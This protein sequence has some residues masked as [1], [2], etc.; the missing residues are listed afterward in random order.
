MFTYYHGCNSIAE[1]INI[2]NFTELKH[3]DNG[4][5]FYCSED[6]EV[7][8]RYGKYVVVVMTDQRADITRP[9]N[10]DPALTP[11]E[12]MKLGMESVFVT[13]ASAQGLFVDADVV[14][15]QLGDTIVPGIN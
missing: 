7:A 15:V 12:Q 2:I 4:L 14:L 1:C 3:N 11:S 8:E 9:I 6:K 13:Q 10:S 5:G